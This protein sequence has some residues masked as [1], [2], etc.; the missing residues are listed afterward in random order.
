MKGIKM[1]LAET[2]RNLNLPADAVAKLS[3]KEGVDVFVHNE[4]DTEDGLRE[5]DTANRFASLITTRGLTVTSGYTN[6][7]VLQAMRDNDLL[8][9]YERGD[10]AFEEFVAEVIRDS[11]W[12]HEW[13]DTSTE[14]Y[15]HKRGFCTVS[16]NVNVPVQ[17]LIENETAARG[18]K[19][20]V[21]TENGT[22]CV[23]C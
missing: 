3:Y 2:L 11:H 4:T 23:D 22:L 6:E 15:D 18:W 14:R 16:A 10:F 7:E 13:V 17:Q 8:D 21:Q 20:S 19:V 5:T 9:D 1:S 12:D